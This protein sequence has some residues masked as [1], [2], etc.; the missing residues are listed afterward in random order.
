MTCTMSEMTITL[1]NDPYIIMEGGRKKE[2]KKGER[3]IGDG[4]RKKED[5]K[6][7]CKF[8]FLHQFLY[9]Q[10]GLFPIPTFCFLLLTGIK[11]PWVRD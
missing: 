4:R 11:S 3:D 2:K 5:R 1:Q 7:V 10:P 6:W 8:N 9:N